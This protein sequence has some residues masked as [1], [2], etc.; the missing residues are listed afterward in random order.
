MPPLEPPEKNKEPKNIK[1]DP[2]DLLQHPICHGMAVERGKL[3][4]DP[5]I[6]CSKSR[7]TINFDK[8]AEDEKQAGTELGQAQL[9]HG[10]GVY[11][12]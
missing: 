7:S 6:L 12:D 10:T 8:I 4:S 11:F 5:R 2:G 1:R 9:Q 3:I